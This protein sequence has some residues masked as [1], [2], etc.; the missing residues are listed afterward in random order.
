MMQADTAGRSLNIMRCGCSLCHSAAPAETP[1]FA[2]FSVIVQ[3]IGLECGAL[4]ALNPSFVMAVSHA[5]KNKCVK[6]S[7]HDDQVMG[8]W[9]G[10]VLKYVSQLLIAVH[11]LGTGTA[12]VIACAGNNYSID[13]SHSKR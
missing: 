7:V 6:P 5:F 3:H 12:Q 2:L 11:L 8:Y 10:P 9:G 13:H 1:L 4:S